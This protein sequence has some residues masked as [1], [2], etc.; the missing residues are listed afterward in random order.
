MAKSPLA[1][2]IVAHIGKLYAIEEHCQEHNFSEEEVVRYRKEKAWPVLSEIKAR[3]EK[4]AH[5]VAPKSVLEK[6]IGYFFDNWPRLILY[7]E[8]GFLPIDNNA[9]E[10]AIRPFVL[11]RKNWLFSGSPRGARASSILY[12]IIETAKNCGHEPLV[13]QA[14]QPIGI[15][16]IFSKSFPT[17]RRMKKSA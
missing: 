3:L 11:G 1:Q 8:H 5:H 7:L 15:C 9:V 13:R 14:H 16:A 6:A 10:N 12:S 17:R 4:E 2:A